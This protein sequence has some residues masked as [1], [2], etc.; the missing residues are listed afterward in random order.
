MDL[1]VG[2]TKFTSIACLVD[3]LFLTE[4]EQIISRNAKSAILHTATCILIA[5]AT[6]IQ[7]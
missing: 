7:R 3:K 5:K 6:E 2:G 4:Q 1:N